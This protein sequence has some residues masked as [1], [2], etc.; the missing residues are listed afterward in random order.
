MH[1]R[2]SNGLSLPGAVVVLAL[3]LASGGLAAAEPGRGRLL[4]DMHCISCHDAQA[5]KRDSK[6]ASNYDEVRSQVLRWQNNVFLRWSAE[7]IDAVA[8]YLARAF[9]KL[10]CPDC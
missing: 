9:Y 6:I 7:D 5:Y 3:A 8:T 2:E 10:P 4:H 1:T